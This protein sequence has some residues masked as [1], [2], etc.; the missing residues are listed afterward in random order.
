MS[1]TSKLYLDHVKM[2]ETA[3]EKGDATAAKSLAYL[4]L[5]CSGWRYG[6]PDPK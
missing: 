2:L 3:A 5:G 6:D 1:R 4:S